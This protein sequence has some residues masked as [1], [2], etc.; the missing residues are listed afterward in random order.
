MV[1]TNSTMLPLGAPMPSFRLRDVRTDAPV[2]DSDVIG[3]K[4][5]LVMFICRH[6]PYVKHVEVELSKIGSDYKNSGIGV[7][8]VSSN[9]AQGYPDDAPSSLAQM[10]AELGFVFPLLYD[11]DQSVAQAYRA[12]CTPDFFLFDGAGRLAYR[13]QLDSSRPGSGIPVTGEDLRRALDA[14]ASG[15]SPDSAQTPSLGCNIKWKSGN[16]PDYF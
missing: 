13:G 11:E 8:A 10:A 7:V 1:K 14:L 4:G 5:L 6:C 15:R 2:C 16:E 12:A 9:D 3:E